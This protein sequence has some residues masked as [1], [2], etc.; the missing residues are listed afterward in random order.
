MCFLK[1]VQTP[2]AS[3][4]YFHTK[5]ALFPFFALLDSVSLSGSVDSG[6]KDTIIS[7]QVPVSIVFK[8]SSQKIDTSD[9]AFY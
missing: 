6:L 5:H 4:S 7:Q 2:N 3:F 9:I 8:V 1:K